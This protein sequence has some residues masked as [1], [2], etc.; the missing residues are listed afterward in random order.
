MSQEKR[1]GFF[2]F[3]F[4]SCCVVPH[5]GQNKNSEFICFFL[6]LKLPTIT[7]NNFK[8]LIAIKCLQQKI[9]KNLFLTLIKNKNVSRNRSHSPHR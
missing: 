5:S 4:L 7:K 1:N 3:F 2:F 9:N 6:K 8:N